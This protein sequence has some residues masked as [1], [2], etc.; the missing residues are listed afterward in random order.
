SLAPRRRLPSALPPIRAPLAS[1]AAHG[2][3]GDRRANRRPRRGA[4]DTDVRPTGPP[5]RPSARVRVPNELSRDRLDR[6]ARHLRDRVAVG[7]HG[8]PGPLVARPPGAGPRRSTPPA[9]P[10]VARDDLGI[11]APPRRGL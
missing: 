7:I 9:R 10:V 3:A 11:A 4:R 1:R 5:R 8:A 2:G 6:R